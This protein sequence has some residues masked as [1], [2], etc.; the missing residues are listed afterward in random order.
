ARVL[1]AVTVTAGSDPSCPSGSS[2]T[3]VDVSCPGVAQR[4]GAVVASRPAQGQPRGLVVLFSGELGTGWWATS[5]AGAELLDRLAEDHLATVQVRW[6]AGWLTSAVGE[7]AG[8]AALACRPATVIQW[9]HDHIYGPLGVSSRGAGSCGFCVTGNSGGASAVAYAAS[10]YPVVGIDAVLLTSGPPHAAM[11][12]GCLRRG[13]EEAYWYSESAARIVDQS[14]GY[15]DGGPCETHL[16]SFAPRWEADEADTASRALA[17]APRSHVVVG[18]LD[19]THAPEHA[20]AYARRI[21]ATIEHVANMDHTI[22]Q[23]ID[24]LKALRAAL[25][26]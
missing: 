9:V 26:V 16:A 15:T 20:A 8:P 11:V 18:D 13:G 22:Q 12:Q 3:S 5:G 4:L 19:T 10:E 25:L 17:T 21:G 23:S 7:Q 2:C 1:G 14:Y 6:T 24:G